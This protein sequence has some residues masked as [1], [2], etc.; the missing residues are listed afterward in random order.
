MVIYDEKRIAVNTISK[1]NTTPIQVVDSINFASNT[2]LTLNGIAV[3]AAGGSG[4][5]SQVSSIGY[6]SSFTNYY[7]TLTAGDIGIAFQVGSPP[8]VPLTVTAG[9]TT[10]IT[11][12]LVLSG[13]GTP[14]LGSYLTCMDS[15]GT[16]QWQPPGSV[17]DARWK[18]DI[19][20]IENADS[21]LQTIRGVR[22]SWN[23]SGSNDIGLIAQ[24]L[25]PALPE[26]V[27]VGLGEQ[28]HT[29]HYHKIIPVLVEAVKALQ[30]RVKI[31]ENR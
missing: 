14:T 3:S 28:P 25:L 5:F 11:G 13:A 16:A 8:I 7:S 15:L 1:Y 10:A 17:S 26:A 4:S 30:E 29:V 23:S 20:P 6:A 22:F 31:L 19:R 9:G 18:G 12:N 2:S 24:D 27:V 21:I